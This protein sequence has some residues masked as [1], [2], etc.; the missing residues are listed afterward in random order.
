MLFTPTHLSLLEC[1]LKNMI[2]RYNVYNINYNASFFTEKISV[3]LLR[4]IK[5][6]N[7]FSAINVIHTLI[8]IKQYFLLPLYQK[9]TRQLNIN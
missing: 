8:C 2:L 7:V 6:N 5:Y 3:F 4:I 1:I 9:Y